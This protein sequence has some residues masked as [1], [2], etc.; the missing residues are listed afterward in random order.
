M[1]AES[2]ERED[3]RVEVVRED[4]LPTDSVVVEWRVDGACRCSH[5]ANGY[6]SRS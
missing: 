1:A 3:E 4:P 5:S 6:Q 2:S